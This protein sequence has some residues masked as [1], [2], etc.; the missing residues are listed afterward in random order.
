MEPI[1]EQLLDRLKATLAILRVNHG[2]ILKEIEKMLAAID[3]QLD[4]VVGSSNGGMFE[5]QPHA[6]HK[7]RLNNW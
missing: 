2:Q 5:N 1:V 4:K 7:W 6:I 3:S